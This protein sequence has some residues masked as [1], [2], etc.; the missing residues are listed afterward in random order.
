MSV[1]VVVPVK[2][3]IGAAADCL[4]PIV[5]AAIEATIEHP[6]PGTTG[7]ATAYRFFLYPFLKN[8]DGV[9]SDYYLERIFPDDE[10]AAFPEDQTKESLKQGRLEG[11]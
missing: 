4:I 1:N 11:D 2:K 6:V 3:A 9:F 10:L 8:S 5:A 7:R